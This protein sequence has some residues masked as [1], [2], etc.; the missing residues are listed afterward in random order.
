MIGKRCQIYFTNDIFSQ[1]WQLP[2]VMTWARVRSERK[3]GMK[4]KE[5]H[6][7]EEW[8]C[9]MWI[10]EDGWEEGEEPKENR[11]ENEFYRC[12]H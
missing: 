2:T 5:Q 6:Q 4:G 10:S 8:R 11:E 7:R 1:S 12:L 3:I 9:I